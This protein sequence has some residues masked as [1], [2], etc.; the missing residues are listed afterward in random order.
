MQKTVISFG[1]ILWDIFPGQ[2]ILGGAP[3]NLA[4]RVASLGE[5]AIIASRLG[6]DELGEKAYASVLSLGLDPS[7]LQWDSTHPTGTVRVTIDERKNPD[8]FI[9][10]GVAYDYMELTDSLL[11]IAAAADYFCFGT[12]VQ[13]SAK[14]RQ[15]VEKLLEAGSGGVKLLDINLRKD[16][17]SPDTVK[18]SL[19]NADILKLNEDEARELSGL[20]FDK[21]YS[22]PGF[23]EAVV[24][25]WT[26]ESCLVTLGEKGV[27]A[28][29]GQGEGIYVP[30][31]IVQL[32]DTV[33]AGDAF[34]AGVVYCLVRNLPLREAVEFGNL[35]GALASTKKGGT[36][37]IT[38]EEIKMFREKETERI[39]DPGL[40]K[41]VSD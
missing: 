32:A 6:R 12:L 28:Y 2:M 25:K 13:R 30:G 22:V 26:L 18:S 31:Y 29:S 34:T 19:E 5:R 39:Y 8:F 1:E 33:G 3:F 17:Y 21:P 20:L 14:T 38:P 41:F 10:P 36:A 40:E 11:E 27:F 37:L 35:L 4:Y 16:C 7:Y 24:E 15:T 23:C 9:V